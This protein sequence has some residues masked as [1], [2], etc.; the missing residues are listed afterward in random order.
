M[1]LFPGFGEDKT[2]FRNLKPFLRDYELIVIDYRKILK[3]IPLWEVTPSLLAKRIGIYYAIQPEDKLVGHSMGGYFA[4]CLSTQQGNPTCLIGS[5]TDANKIV[6]FSHSKLVNIAATGSG[7][8]KTPLFRK[9]ITSRTKNP[10]IRKEMLS[11]QQNFKSFSNAD[12]AK[13][14][15]LSFGETLP[16]AP[17]ESLRIHAKDDRVVRIPDEPYTKVRGGHFSLVFHPD[18]VYAAMENWLTD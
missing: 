18:E 4:Y 2:C 13:M 14:A 11:I 9:Y 15:L 8:I 16:P 10:T 5:F 12:M 3:S 1:F 6:R 7:L 17:I